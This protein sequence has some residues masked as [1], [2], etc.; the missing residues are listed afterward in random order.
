[1]VKNLDAVITRI[2]E[3]YKDTIG[4]GSGLILKKIIFAENQGPAGVRQTDK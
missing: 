4:N 3:L 1:M 2:G